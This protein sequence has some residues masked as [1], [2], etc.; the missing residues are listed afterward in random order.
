MEL[1]F[2]VSGTKEADTIIFIHG[3]GMN[4]KVWKNSIKYFSK[5]NCIAVDLPQHGKS[6]DMKPFSIMKSVECIAEI[7]RNNSNEAKAHVVG[8][9]LGGIILINLICRNPELINHAIVASGNLRPSI[10]Y[11]I[12]SNSLVCNIMSFISHKVNKNDPITS[13]MLK[14]IYQEVVNNT[15]IPQGIHGSEIPTLFIAGEKEPN[16]LKESNK[17]LNRI[18]PNS[19]NILISKANHSYPWEE[20]YIFSEIVDSWISSKEINNERVMY[21]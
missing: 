5:Y 13:D 17:D 6:S 12:L 4:R 18:L 2:E 11:N 16:F 8:H 1:Y 3:G 9:S 21:I 14:R 10:S 15:K 20:H 7:I 19:K